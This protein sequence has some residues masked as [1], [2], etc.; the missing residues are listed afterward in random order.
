MIRRPS[1]LVLTAL[2]AGMSAVAGAMAQ[3]DP[4][5]GRFGTITEKGIGPSPAAATSALASDIV[6]TIVPT[7][8]GHMRKQ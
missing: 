3:G 7:L 8:C 6:A 4:A 1:L 5:E 2:V